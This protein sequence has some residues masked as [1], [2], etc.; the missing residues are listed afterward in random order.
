[1]AGSKRNATLG[2]VGI[3]A[4]AIVL[5]SV[6]SKSRQEIE[7]IGRDRLHS[8]VGHA[9]DKS[10]FW[11]DK[12]SG[13][14]KDNFELRDLPTSNKSELMENFDA[15][16]TVDDVQREDVEAYLDE[17]ANLGKLFQD[18]Y[19]LSHTSGSQGQPLLLVQPPETIELLFALQAARGN[20]T[21][22]ELRRNYQ[23]FVLAG[24]IGG[25]ILQAWVLSVVVRIRI[26]ARGREALYRRVVA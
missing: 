14:S 1:M 9:R 22:V 16:L 17:P 6:N 15:S 12:L 3:C 18:K 24:P 4:K 21:L 2:L 19:A 26:H 11:H 7:A 13:V 8:L 23:A 5:K 10:R 25:R 20:A